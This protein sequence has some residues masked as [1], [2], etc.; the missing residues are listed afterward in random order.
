V[1]PTP[2]PGDIRGFLL[3]HSGIAGAGSVKPLDMSSLAYPSRR[4]SQWVL[5]IATFGGVGFGLGIETNAGEQRDKFP[6]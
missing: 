6:S 4:G 3:G 1:Q 2:L 5:F